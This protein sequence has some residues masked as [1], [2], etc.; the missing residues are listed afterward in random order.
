MSYNKASKIEIAAFAFAGTFAS[1]AAPILL[2]NN[3]VLHNVGEMVGA[4][5][6]A[7]EHT[8]TPEDDMGRDV[9][10]GIAYAALLGAVIG[11]N[12]RMARQRQEPQIGVAEAAATD[13]PTIT[14]QVGEVALSDNGIDYFIYQSPHDI[15]DS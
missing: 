14:S 10:V 7:E 11:F 3:H 13:I 15:H 2:S 12:A 5:Q 8:P 4:E 9:G 6:F 1:T